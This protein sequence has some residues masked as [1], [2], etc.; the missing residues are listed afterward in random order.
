MSKKTAKKRRKANKKAHYGE[1]LVFI[2]IG[3]SLNKAVKLHRHGHTQ[4]A[5]RIYRKILKQEPGN[6][7]ALQLLGAIELGRGQNEQA[8][9]L[10]A[11][12]LAVQPGLPA[13][14]CNM[15]IGLMRLNRH[16]DAA[17]AF[18]K[19][20]NLD[21]QFLL[22]HFYLGRVF[23]DAKLPGNALPHLQTANELRPADSETVVMLA[24]AL[25]LEHG[26]DAALSLVQ[27][28]ISRPSELAQVYL[29]LGQ[30]LRVAQQWQMALTV[31]QKSYQLDQH[32][33]ETIINLA[34][35]LERMNKLDDAWEF[36]KPH[37]CQSSQPGM[38]VSIIAARVKRRQG[39][40]DEARQLA[41]KALLYADS[42]DSSAA[43]YS[44]LG[45][46][47]DKQ[48]NYPVAWEAFTTA[49]QLMQKQAEDLALSFTYAPDLITR[50]TK[51]CQAE[52]LSAPTPA[53]IRNIN[54]PIVFFCGFPRSGTTLMEQILAR[55][56][57][58]VITNE[59]PAL[60]E[61]ANMM[62]E[63]L[64]IKANYPDD[65]DQLSQEELDQ[66]REIYLWRLGV[67][68][69]AKTT[70]IV[71]KMPLN[72]WFIPLA[73]RL[74]PQ[75]KILFALRNPLDTCLR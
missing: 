29:Q 67:K 40:L 69:L 58:I 25:C 4:D 49:N 16:M 63:L 66:L 51:W 26:F 45:T 70:L 54:T 23:L 2:D 55:H 39:K 14:H 1:N 73:L 3:K 52:K 72:T 62:G 74:F 50:C 61:T 34:E 17:E 35:L 10:I 22:A 13:L 56:P 60:S 6:F 21:Q 46:I 20:L 75:A 15:G 53:A 31:L 27:K 28:S 59:V 43:M 8:I 24:E 42:S 48:K 18:Q 5:L 38:V 71:D 32:N 57:Q 30:R 68:K 37:L 36:V 19:A 64:G 9:E 44:E 7:D 11:R 65:I 47:L 33:N 41:K 12:A